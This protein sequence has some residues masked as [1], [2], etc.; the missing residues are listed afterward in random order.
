MKKLFIILA[1]TVLC[2]CIGGG[3][4]FGQS[5]LSD[6]LDIKW[7][8]KIGMYRAN[9]KCYLTMVVTLTNASDK[10]VK[11]RDM[12]F[13]LRFRGPRDLYVGRATRTSDIDVP[14]NRG[15]SYPGEAMAELTF[16]AGPDSGE[17]IDKLFKLVSLIG[18]PSLRPFTM[19]LEGKGEL[20]AERPGGGGW[21]YQAYKG[22][23][24]FE[25]QV[26]S[27]VFLQ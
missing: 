7:V 18:D 15:R 5:D 25:P 16:E 24:I 23:L 10:A 27:R 2:L 11:F 4:V 13:D 6:K 9:G 20:G 21:V 1:V 19:Y 17:T 8:N 22:E 12:T 3:S 26:Q 14:P